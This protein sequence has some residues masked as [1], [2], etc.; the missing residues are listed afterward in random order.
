MHVNWSEIH[1]GFWL[2]FG[3]LAAFMVWGLLTSLVGR[4]AGAAHRGH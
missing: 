2:G 1:M 3:L 4:A